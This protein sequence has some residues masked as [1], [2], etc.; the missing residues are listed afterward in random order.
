MDPRQLFV[1]E[2]LTGFCVYCGAAPESGDHCPSKVLLDEPFPPNL[3]VLD[4]CADCN[5]H[6]S[7]DEQYIACL[8]ET[9]ICGSANPDDVSRPMNGPLSSQVDIGIWSA[10]RMATLFAWC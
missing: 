6:L 9:V 3:P 5:N 7:L 4:A 2:R 10:S 1:D 8:I